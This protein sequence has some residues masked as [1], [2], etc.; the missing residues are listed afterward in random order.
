[1]VILL[2]VSFSLL[3]PGIAAASAVG[4]LA[5]AAEAE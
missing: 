4:A 1:M 3:R 2:A 5:L